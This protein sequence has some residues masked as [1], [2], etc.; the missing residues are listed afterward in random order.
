MTRRHWQRTTETNRGWLKRAAELATCTSTKGDN[1]TYP[2]L[3]E[4]GSTPPPE[5]GQSGTQPYGQPDYSQ[6]YD[7]QAPPPNYGQPQQPYGA[8]PDQSQY[9][10]QQQPNYGQPQYG[11]PGYAQPYGA[12]QQSQYGQPQYGQSPYGATS[13]PPTSSRKPFIIAGVAVA[14]V[15]AAVVLVVVTSGSSSHSTDSNS[16]A[17]NTAQEFFGAIDKHNAPGAYALS[18]DTGQKPPSADVLD[19]VTSA[20][21]TGQAK[22]T[23]NIATATG[24]YE[25]SGQKVGITLHLKR[26]GSAWCVGDVIPANNSG[27]STTN[28]SVVPTATITPPPGTQSSAPVVA[29]P[30]PGAKD[31]THACTSTLGAGDVS[32]PGLV[33]P[34]GL[35]AGLSVEKNS[36]SPDKTATRFTQTISAGTLNSYCFNNVEQQ[37]LAFFMAYLNGGN[38]KPQPVTKKGTVEYINSDPNQKPQHIFVTNTPN[39]VQDENNFGTAVGS[40]EID[41]Y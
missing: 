4:P 25:V 33:A 34:E 36:L 8:Q 41:W 2:P 5:P 26:N 16:G 35:K 40:V 13:G 7:Q 20:A 30:T 27:G 37:D 11:Q 32:D 24:Y 28:P 3:P 22:V 14:A 1:V 15:A 12:P 18:C 6:Q 39:L 31:L 17:T 38:W 23:G 9:G 10:Q 19:G 21:T 29:P